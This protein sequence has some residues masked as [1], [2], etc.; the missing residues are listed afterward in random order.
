MKVSHPIARKL[1]ARLESSA[2][3]VVSA[4]DL[5]DLG[6]RTAVD[7]ALSRLVREGRIQRV[8]RGL[9]AWPRTSA[10]LKRPAIPAPDELAQAWAK[11][12]GLRLVPSGAY[13]ANLLGLTT[14]VPAKITYYT[15]GRTNTLTLGP[16]SI[17]LLNRG[18]KTMDVSGRVSALV[19]QALR[20][21]GKDGVTPEKIARLRTVLHKRDRAEL[22]LA[23]SHA[24][25]WMMPVVQQI[26]DKRSR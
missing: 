7:Q 12:N 1:L 20:Y 8:R 24:P 19:L 17:R 9:Y 18:P 5:L 11:K 4:K 25:A 6:P 3:A 21:L 14:Q 13:A 15:N 16:Y 22:A 23:L 10:L 2:G 26:I